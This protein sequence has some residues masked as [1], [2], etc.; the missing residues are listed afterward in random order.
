MSSK[1]SPTDYIIPLYMNGL[2]GRMLYMPAKNKR[3]EILLVYGQHSTLERW[4]GV[5]QDLNRYGAVTMP[6]LPG[7]GG[8]QSFYKIGRQPTLD[9]FADYLA[10]FIKLRYKRKKITIVSLGFGFA[11]VTR[12]LQR[13]PDLAPKV[14]LLVSVSGFAHH[15]D[16]VISPVR[17]RV[18]RTGTR[19]FS[20][21]LASVFLRNVG[22]HPVF[23]RPALA[24]RADGSKKPADKKASI[25]FEMHLWHVN[26]I[27]THMKTTAARLAL[28][29]CKKVVALPVWQITLKDDDQ[30]DSYR[31]EQHLKVIFTDLNTATTS[32]DIY[33]TPLVQD[34]K[35]ARPLLPSRLRQELT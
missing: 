23:L 3:R 20:G 32:L 33:T 7:F 29:N 2:Q 12:M 21:R 22:L 30:F 6:D 8:M 18:M 34:Q 27:R 14:E 25:D 1:K 15:S 17:R 19:L 5:A 26:D 10:S 35:S 28:D 11:I 16:W 13:F 4:W 24:R 31:Q 9:N